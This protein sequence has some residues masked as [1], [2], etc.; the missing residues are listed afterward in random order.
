MLRQFWARA[1][2][3]FRENVARYAVLATA[4][5]TPVAGLLGELAADVG[6]AD[7]PAGRTVLAA[8]A[9]IGTA[10]AAVTFIRNLGVWQMLDTFGVAP[11]T[12]P[13]ED[14]PPAGPPGGDARVDDLGPAADAIANGSTITGERVIAQAAAENAALARAR[15]ALE[16]LGAAGDTTPIRNLSD[17][18]RGLGSSPMRMPGELAVRPPAPDLDDSVHAATDGMVDEPVGGPPIDEEESIPEPEP[19][20]LDRVDAGD[21]D[22]DPVGELEGL[23]EARPEPITPEEWKGDDR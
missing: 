21:D 15:A 2:G 14:V 18:E 17:F 1:R 7:T 16:E 4:I 22:D 3:H 5:L 11:N 13:A 10:I 8:S 23:P 6:G 19:A 9:A 20:P 12:P